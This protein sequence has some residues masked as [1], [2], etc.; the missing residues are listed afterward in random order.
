MSAYKPTLR[1]KLATL[2]GGDAPQGSLRRMLT[3]TFVGPSVGYSDKLAVADLVPVVGTALQAQEGG[4]DLATPGRRLS[5]AVNLGMALIP[6]AKGA[7]GL[8]KGGEKGVEKLAA[9]YGLPQFTTDLTP[10]QI[11]ANKAGK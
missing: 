10:A 6:G 1:N 8:V 11:E 3:D 4:R 2:A 7:K 5:G 9:K